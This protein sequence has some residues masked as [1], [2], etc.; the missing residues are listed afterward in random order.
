MADP[1]HTQKQLQTCFSTC[2]P[3]GRTRRFIVFS[4]IDF[5]LKQNTMGFRQNTMGFKQN[6]IGFKQNTMG[7]KQN[8][9]FNQ[10]M[11]CF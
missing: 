6:M 1:L 2:L 3:M 9:G 8:M 4:L 10:N 7:F 5:C 11:I